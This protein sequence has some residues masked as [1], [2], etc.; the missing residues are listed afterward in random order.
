MTTSYEERTE[1]VGKSTGKGAKGP[2]DADGTASAVPKSPRSRAFVL[3]AV[4]SLALLM[5]LSAVRRDR[6]VQHSAR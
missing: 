5:R 1:P 2:K 3:T 4:L 6:R